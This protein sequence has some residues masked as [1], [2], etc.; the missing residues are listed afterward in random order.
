METF[1]NLG[2]AFKAL[3]QGG[4]MPC[5]LNAAN[6]IAVAAFLK[7]EIGFLEMSDLLADCMVKGTFLPNPSLEDYITT[8]KLTREMAQMWVNKQNK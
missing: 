2:L 1:R 6:E 8:D 3:D 7:D 4:N 5:I